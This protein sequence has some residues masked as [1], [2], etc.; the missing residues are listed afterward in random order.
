[1]VEVLAARAFG[2]PVTDAIHPADAGVARGIQHLRVVIGEQAAR[3]IET[4]TRTGRAPE[5]RILLGRPELVRA[6]GAI[7]QVQH[8]GL[9]MLHGQRDRMRIG[10]QHQPLAGGAHVPQ[11]FARA[12]QPRHVRAH[13]AVQRADVHAQRPRPVVDAIPIQRAAAF[14][15]PP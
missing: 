13:L 3:G 11:E 5:S 12:G 7:E 10:E 6:G 8:A 1:V 15:E 9:L 2:I 14:G 4:E